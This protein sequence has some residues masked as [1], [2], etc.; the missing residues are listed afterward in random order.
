MFQ[1]FVS[2]DI[3]G[4]MVQS[5]FR[6]QSLEIPTLLWARENKPPTSQKQHLR[7]LTASFMSTSLGWIVGNVHRTH[8][9]DMILAKHKA[10]GPDNLTCSLCGPTESATQ[11]VFWLDVTVNDLTPNPV[12]NSGGN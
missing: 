3:T 1:A 12:Q 6:I 11:Q 4:G 10:H 8:G 5:C 2:Q 7:W 9:R